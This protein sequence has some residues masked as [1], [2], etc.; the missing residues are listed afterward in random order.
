MWLL[1]LNVNRGHP[2]GRQCALL[3]RSQPDVLC[4]QEVRESHVMHLEALGYRGS[5][6]AQWYEVFEGTREAVG[7]GTFTKCEIL[8]FDTHPF[9]RNNNTPP[10]LCSGRAT[11]ET[12]PRALHEINIAK[13]G[14]TFTLFN[15]HFTW[16]ANGAPSELQRLDACNLAQL[17]HKTH[18][19]ILCGDMNAPLGEEI[20][21]ILQGGMVWALSDDIQTSIDP[22]YHYNKDL[23]I[24]VDAVFCT[25]DLSVKR[26][27]AQFGVSDH[28][29]FFVNFS[30]QD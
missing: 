6:F 2:F 12:I 13:N 22:R 7:L 19:T 29:A 1:S 17:T 21:T 10:D 3:R 25:P 27:W 23:R 16:S 9:Q 28:A 14:A 15:V 18:R 11:Q 26:S 30:D 4:L 8:G 24:L 20:S 5:F